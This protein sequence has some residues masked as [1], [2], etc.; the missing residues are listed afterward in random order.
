MTKFLGNHIRIHKNKVHDCPNSGIRANK[1]DYI[2]I[3]ENEVYRNTWWSSNAESAIVLAD[4]RSIDDLN[5]TKMFLVRNIVYDNR[6]F[7]P[8]YNANY[9]DPNYLEEHQMHS[10]RPGYGTSNQTFII[11]GSGK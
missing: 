10:A 7:I 3:E 1:G 8:Y 2:S 4:A 11:D 6:N 9:D 5:I